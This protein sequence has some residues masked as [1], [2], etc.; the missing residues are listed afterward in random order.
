MLAVT[1][2]RFTRKNFLAAY[3][4]THLFRNKTA[5]EISLSVYTPHDP[6]STS[7]PHARHQAA[8]R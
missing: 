6:F 2:F 7:F 8:A 4:L 1:Y 5:G 3:F